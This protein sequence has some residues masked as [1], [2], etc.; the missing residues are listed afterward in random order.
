MTTFQDLQAEHEALLNRHEAPADPAQFWSDV[1]RFIDR[2]RVDAE[3]IPAP[4]ERD[5]LR[6]ILRF[7]ASYVFDKTGSYPD[8]TLRP[9]MGGESSKAANVEGSAPPTKPPTP[10]ESSQRPSVI[11]GIAAL[12]VVAVVVAVIALGVSNRSAS[13]PQTGNTEFV[14]VKTP[15]ASVNVLATA[16]PP[17]APTL[18]IQWTI[19][20]TGPSPFD[21]NV[22]ATRLQLSATGGNGSYIFW[23]NGVRLPDVSDNQFT[24][25]GTGCESK[26]PVV[27]VTSGGQATSLELI[28]Q[29]PLNCPQP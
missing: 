7:W 3:Q 4:R 24:V 6:A 9:A 16:E 13:G 27:G 10:T 28:I 1:Q 14:P 26:K 11:W 25:E 18:E 20:T 2:V 22:W 23:V 17:S 8:T 5:Q 19:L 12:A 21:P 15:D 29:S